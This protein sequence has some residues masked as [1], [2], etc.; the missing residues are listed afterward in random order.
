MVMQYKRVTKFFYYVGFMGN[1]S[2][3]LEF[4]TYSNQHKGKL[5]ECLIKNVQY[6]RKMFIF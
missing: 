1:V 5:A 3:D 6:A 2:K 4:F